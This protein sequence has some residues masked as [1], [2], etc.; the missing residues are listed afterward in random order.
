MTHKPRYLSLIGVVAVAAVFGYAINNSRPTS[1]APPA[2]LIPSFEKSAGVGSYQQRFIN[3]KADNFIHSPSIA[4]L[5]GGDL[6]A[7][8]FEGSR[9]GAA[10]VQIMQSRFVAAENR[11]TEPTVLINRESTARGV[12]RYIRKLG[13][14][15]AARDANGKVFVFFVSV[16]VGGWAG[17]AIN[18][19]ASTDDAKTWSAP[20]RL[21][22]TPFFNISTLVRNPPVLHENGVIGLPVYHE[23]LGKFPE[24]LLISDAGRV[25]DKIRMNRGT[26]S[27]QP[28]IAPIDSDTAMAV[29]RYAGDGLPRALGQITSNRGAQWPKPQALAIANPNSS[30]ASVATGLVEWPL[31]VVANDTEDDRYRLRMY[32]TDAS[33]SQW[34]MIYAPDASPNEDGKLYNIEADPDYIK[35]LMSKVS[36][37]AMDDAALVVKNRVCRDGKSCELQYEYPTLIRASN[38]H[39]HLVYAWNDMLIKHVVFDQAWLEKQIAQP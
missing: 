5:N 33:M 18:W 37:S 9:E 15:V 26:E 19:I 8:W 1:S 7:V 10:D 21:I 28:S 38:G 24:Y 20:K 29:L 32:V 2:F 31:L 22:T 36:A 39:Y 27:L 12:G 16:S 3:H 14:P 34:K 11:W 30:L 25:I 6:L 13:N 4:E 35:N 23:F 17:S